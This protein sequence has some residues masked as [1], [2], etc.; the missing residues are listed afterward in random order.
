MQLRGWFAFGIGIAAMIAAWGHHGEAREQMKANDPWLWLEDVRGARPLAWVRQENARTLEVLAGDPDY[1]R[2]YD[3]VLSILDAEDR[4]PFGD[5]DRQ[6]VFNFWQDQKNPKGVWRRATIA[7]YETANPHW[8]TLLD[9]DGLAEAEH[10]NWVFK[11]ATCSP[12]LLRCLVSLSRGGGDAAVVREFDLATKKFSANGF[13]LPEAKSYATYLDEDTILFGTDFGTDSLTSSGYPRIVKVWN[14]GEPIA[15]AKEALAGRP[16]DVSVSPTALRAPTGS[17]GV[18]IRSTTFFE[19][20]YYLPAATGEWKRLPLPLSAVLQ[21]MTG[22]QLIFTLRGDWATPEGRK[23]EK[24]TVVAID[25]N[26]FLAGGKLPPAIVL[27][28]PHARISVEQVSCGRDF[29]YAAVYDNVVGSVHAF[30]FDPGK[31]A[32]RETKLDLPGGGAT[33]IVTANDY[34]PEAQFRFES[35]L[36]PTTLYADEGSDHPRAIK[37]IPARFDPSGLSATQ[38]EATSR[39]GTKIPYFVVAPPGAAEPRPT[40]LYGYGGFEISQTPWYWANA[41]KLW[42]TRG[43]AIAVANIRGGGE[44]GPAWHDAAVKIHRQ[45]AFDDFAAVAADLSARRITTPRQLG[46]MGGS[47]GGLL[48]STVMTQHPELVGAVVCQV[49]LTDMLRYTKIGAG[50]S[51]IGEYGDPENPA[52]RAAILKYSPYQNV[53][54]GVKYP[55]V[56]FVTATSDDRVTPAHARKMAAKMLTQGHDVLFFENTEG[57]HAAAADHRQAAEM[58]ALSFVYLKERLGLGVGSGVASGTLAVPAPR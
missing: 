25:V 28:A 8:E 15:N 29:V 22:G 16:K 21:G 5:I 53:R 31:N 43:G 2:D 26:P 54:P 23:I 9:L 37:S 20:E 6:Y 46:I 7:D 18:I 10:E 13:T 51:W 55:P 32:W 48:V 57:G 19:T 1:R 35:F 49:P 36:T 17:L 34:G 24:G 14:R 41:G 40:I 3:A 56:L 42:L 44:F 12:S 39:D 50:A 11:G 45:R 47:N 52:M 33:Q 30:R 58:W 27:Y 38:H 4:V